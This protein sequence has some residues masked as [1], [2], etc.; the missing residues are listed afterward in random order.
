LTNLIFLLFFGVLTVLGY[1]VA[2]QFVVAFMLGDNLKK[3]WN[4]IFLLTIFLSFYMLGKL[5]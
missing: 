3:F 4:H 2:H 5:F 1:L